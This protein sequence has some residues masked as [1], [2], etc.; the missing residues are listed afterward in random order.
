MALT[1]TP[2]SPSVVLDILKLTKTKAK[3]SPIN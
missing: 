3:Y 1:A 2:L